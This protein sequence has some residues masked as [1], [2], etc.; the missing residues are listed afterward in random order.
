MPNHIYLL[1]ISLA[2]IISLSDK[3][4][5]RL[6]PIVQENWLC[7]GG[8]S[9]FVPIQPALFCIENYLLHQEQDRR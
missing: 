1:V 6:F 8:P 4:F 3:A 9:S 2:T 5:E 7:L